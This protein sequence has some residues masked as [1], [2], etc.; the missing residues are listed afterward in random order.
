VS[1]ITTSADFFKEQNQL[2]QY[3]NFINIF[4]SSIIPS[5]IKETVEV[6]AKLYSK[7]WYFFDIH[8]ND[9]QSPA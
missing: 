9:Q 1:F 5:V 7:Y 3:L 2:Y 6:I 8:I 4:L